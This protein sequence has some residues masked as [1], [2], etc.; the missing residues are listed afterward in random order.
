[1][2]KVVKRCCEDDSRQITEHARRRYSRTCASAVRAHTS[3]HGVES[4][5]GGLIAKERFRFLFVIWLATPT[6]LQ[7]ILLIVVDINNKLSLK[8]CESV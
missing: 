2:T 5:L 4:I 1:M 3:P 7:E 6:S 8:N